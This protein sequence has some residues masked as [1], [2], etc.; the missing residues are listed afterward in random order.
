MGESIEGDGRETWTE[1]QHL[2]G[3]SKVGVILGPGLVIFPCCL[4]TLHN[5]YCYYDYYYY[6]Y[7]EVQCNIQWQFDLPGTL[8]WSLSIFFINWGSINVACVTV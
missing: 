1:G 7:L 2:R 3:N 6:F 4:H 5:D 8:E